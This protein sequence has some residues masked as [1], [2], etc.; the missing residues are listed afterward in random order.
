MKKYR[1]HYSPIVYALMVLV[2]LAA[3]AGIVLNVLRC[4][5]R[6]FDVSTWNVLTVAI[7]FLTC[8]LL[9]VVVLSLF[10]RTDYTF[11]GAKLT[12]HYG[13]IK[14]EIALAAATE[15][16]FYKKTEKLVLYYDEDKYV[17]ILLK[18]E[19]HEEFIATC[20]AANENLRYDTRTSPD[21]DEPQK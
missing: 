11:K 6:E 8:T 21:E 19:K 9:I 12:I 17:V 2:L 13:I 4:I 5:S 15:I 20:R 16:V 3:G 7:M 18:P 14:N 10:I 1:F